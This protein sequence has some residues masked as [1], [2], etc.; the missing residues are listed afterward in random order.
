[1]TTQ[2]P[3]SDTRLSQMKGNCSLNFFFNKIFLASFCKSYGLP[4]N[5][6]WNE[7]L[8]IKN[9]SNIQEFNDLFFKDLPNRLNNE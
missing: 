3:L 8:T 7:L 6:D 4:T 2:K 5:L 9:I 1:M